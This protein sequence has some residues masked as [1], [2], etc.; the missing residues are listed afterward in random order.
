MR[1]AIVCGIGAGL[2]L[3]TGVSALRDGEVLLA[4]V[5]WAFAALTAAASAGLVVVNGRVIRQRKIAHRLGFEDLHAY[6]QAR[7]SAGVSLEQMAAETGL[8][9]KDLRTADKMWEELRR[10]RPLQE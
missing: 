9:P 10:R 8:K 1:G 5:F 6:S 3:V 4:I 2:F 7:K